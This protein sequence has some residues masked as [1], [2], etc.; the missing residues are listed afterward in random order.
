LTSLK[1]KILKN[2]K[3]SSKRNQYRNGVNINECI[4]ELKNSDTV[5]LGFYK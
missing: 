4:T 5:D 1:R 3:G 2:E